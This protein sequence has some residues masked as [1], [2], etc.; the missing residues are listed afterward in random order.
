LS[1]AH[2]H[3]SAVGGL[4]RKGRRRVGFKYRL[5][6]QRLEILG[7]RTPEKSDGAV[8]ENEN[9]GTIYELTVNTLVQM[10]FWVILPI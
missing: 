3:Q 1:V 5:A 10:I 7:S 6:A 4:R 2:Q 8:C 9:F